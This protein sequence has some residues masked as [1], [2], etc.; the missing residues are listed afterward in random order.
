MNKMPE[1]LQCSATVISHNIAT[2]RRAL[3]YSRRHVSSALGYR[4]NGKFIERVEQS[5]Q[6]IP[7][8]YL[9]AIAQVLH[10]KDIRE[11]FV[12]DRFLR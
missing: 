1:P 4:D 7:A 11:F 10:V 9:P 5:G 2:R 8:E 12:K 6:S 3:G